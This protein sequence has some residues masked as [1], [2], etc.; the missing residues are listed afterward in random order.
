MLVCEGTAG[1]LRSKHT[2]P[3]RTGPRHAHELAFARKGKR[4]GAVVNPRAH[5]L[6][7]VAR[8]GDCSAWRASKCV[9][10]RF[11][12]AISSDFDGLLSDETFQFGDFGF[13]LVSVSLS[14]KGFLAVKSGLAFPF[15]DAVGVQ[16]VFA[17]GLRHGLSGFEFTQD[18]L[19]ELFGENA[20]FETHELGSLSEGYHVNSLSQIPSAIH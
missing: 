7:P 18:L 8:G 19:F 20:A 15:A 12:K 3:V 9:K 6:P 17:G 1:C 13:F 14:G 5:G 4:I 10:A 2:Q 11:K 16:L